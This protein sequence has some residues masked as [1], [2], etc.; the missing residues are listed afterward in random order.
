MVSFSTVIH[1]I[2][3]YLT[4]NVVYKCT[5]SD[6]KLFIS[7]LFDVEQEDIASRVSQSQYVYWS[8]VARLLGSPRFFFIRNF[9]HTLDLRVS[10]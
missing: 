8:L 9:I 3:A 4:S 7:R 10:G 6:V 5:L 2:L 1:G